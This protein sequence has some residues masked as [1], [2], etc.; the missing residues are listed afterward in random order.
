VREGP[1]D[2]ATVP[3]LGVTDVAGGTGQQWQFARRE[4]G[5][6]EIVMPGQ[7]PDR[8]VAALVP[9]VGQ[10]AEPADVDEDVGH[11]QPQLHQRNQG[12]PARQELRVL[13]E[14]GGQFQRLAD[15][16]GPAVAERCRDHGA[17][18]EALAS[19][20]AAQTRS[21]VVGISM[22]RTPR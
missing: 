11:G 2:G 4:G 12:V 6:L 18:S 10:V 1:A 9:D 14:L 19:L 21:G 8:D 20:I 15:R 13:A 16:R 3:H 22:C 5:V 7:R 17:T